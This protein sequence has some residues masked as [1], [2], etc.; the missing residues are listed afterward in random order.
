MSF[1]VG[2]VLFVLAACPAEQE[3]SAELALENIERE[4]ISFSR[5]MVFDFLADNG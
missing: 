2:F 1:L 5:K 4:K 3:M